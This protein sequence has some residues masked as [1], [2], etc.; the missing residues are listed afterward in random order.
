MAKI[1]RND[2]VLVI[3]GK[4]RGKTGVVRRILPREN[5]LVVEGL[6]L[7][8][9]EPGVYDMFCLPLRLVGSDGA[10]A[11]VILRRS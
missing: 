4:D 1:R 7:A 10:P 2:T 8:E 6:N 9:V 5:R 3:T 11:R